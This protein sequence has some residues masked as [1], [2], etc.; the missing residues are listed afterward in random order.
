MRRPR[1]RF[2]AASAGVLHEACSN[3]AIRSCL[4]RRRISANA[5]T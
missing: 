5:K 1:A 2:R 3:R 4:R